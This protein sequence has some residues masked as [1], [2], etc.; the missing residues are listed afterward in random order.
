MTCRR[1]LYTMLAMGCFPVGITALSVL[2][3]R[4]Q[5]L[6]I[7]LLRFFLTHSLLISGMATPNCLDIYS[8]CP[9]TFLSLV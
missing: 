9:L 6:I 1:G 7:C 2:A 4:V 8:W 5:V 3:S